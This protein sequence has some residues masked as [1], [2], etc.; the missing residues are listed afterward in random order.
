MLIWYFI[1][2]EF[3]FLAQWWSGSDLTVFLE[4]PGMMEYV[5]K[6]HVICTMNHKYDIEWLLA[7]CLTERLRLLGVGV[8]HCLL[9]HELQCGDCNN[10]NIIMFIVA[11]EQLN[12]YTKIALYD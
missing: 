9:L 10:N 4:D 2:A 11:T 6:E 7:W 8:S 3:T 12:K 5:G 1:F